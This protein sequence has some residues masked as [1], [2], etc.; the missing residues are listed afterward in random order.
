[1]PAA[2]LYDLQMIGTAVFV[3]AVALIFGIRAAAIYRHIEMPGW[4]TSNHDT[5]AR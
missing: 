2:S 4:L 3:V 1:M 5:R